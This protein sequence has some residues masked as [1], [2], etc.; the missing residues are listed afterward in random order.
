MET[1]KQPAGLTV[2]TIT[3]TYVRA[4]RSLVQAGRLFLDAYTAEHGPTFDL[5]QAN[6]ELF[7]HYDKA[8]EIIQAVIVE[9]AEL[10]AEADTE[11]EQI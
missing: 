2:G 8:R 4:L 1:A 3:A 5:E 6:P 7:E 9:R 11:P 10:Y